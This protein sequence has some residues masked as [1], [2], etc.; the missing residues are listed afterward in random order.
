MAVPTR[1]ADNG[2]VDTAWGDAVHDTVV[3]QDWQSGSVTLSWA[4]SS[5][6]GV[7]TVTFPRAFSSAVGV[8]VVVSVLNVNF[9][10][11]VQAAPSASQV[12]IQGRR[13]DGSS[14]T[15]SIVAHWIATGPRL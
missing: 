10:V 5:L 7:V 11:S 1:P 9:T 3:A 12:T 14:Q 13:G 6:S 8:I 15:T 4:A 2:P